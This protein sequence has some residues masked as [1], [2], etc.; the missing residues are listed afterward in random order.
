MYIII[1][2]MCVHKNLH[3]VFWSSHLLLLPFHPYSQISKFKK[4]PPVARKPQIHTT[5]QVPVTAK[6]S[7]AIPKDITKLRW[8]G[9]MKAPQRMKRG[10]AVSDGDVVYFRRDASNQIFSY[11]N[12]LGKEHWSSLPDA[13]YLGCSLVVLEG[14]LTAIGGFIYNSSVV[15]KSHLFCLV[16]SDRREWRDN[17]YP[18]MPTARSASASMT[19][20]KFLVVAGGYIFD[21]VEAMSISDKYW[22]KVCPMP[23]PLIDASAAV[24]G[25]QLYLAGGYSREGASK[26]VLTCSLSDLLPPQSPDTRL[27]TPSS[28]NKTGVW[29]STKDLPVTRSTLITLGGH[30]LAIGGK[31]VSREFTSNVY[32]YDSS[33]DSWML[34]S[35]MTTKRSRCLAAALTGDQCLIV[36]GWVSP[37]TTTDT[38][39]IAYFQ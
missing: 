6:T 5:Q 32:R 28:D 1:I 15:L 12:I 9:G 22:I 21:T 39:E 3:Q 19:T 30:L 20:E 34:T 8:K 24:L 17:V 7:T 26:S 31:D 13:P 10:A 33:I 2:I 14:L 16:G 36:G 11:Q 37:F 27:H 4:P 38:V 23:Y 35:H 25:D 29:R 18:P